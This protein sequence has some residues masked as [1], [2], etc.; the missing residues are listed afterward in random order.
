MAALSSRNVLLQFDPALDVLPSGKRLSGGM[1]AVATIANTLWLTH[2]ETVAIE[3]LSAK[4]TNAASFRYTNHRRF[5]LRN[6]VSLPGPG[7]EAEHEPVPEGDFEGIS[8]CGDYLWVAGS[9]SALRD[10]PEGRTG[11]DGIAALAA[12]RRSGNRFVLA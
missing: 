1:S 3:R 8:F 2:D 9:H 11:S 10:G 12:V 6:F 5:D 7:A 4:R